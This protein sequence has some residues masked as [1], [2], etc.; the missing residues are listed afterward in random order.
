MLLVIASIVEASKKRKPKKRNTVPSTTLFDTSPKLAEE[1]PVRLNSEPKSELG[2]GKASDASTGGAS[3][4]V[5]GDKEVIAPYVVPEG[6]D[7][8]S[9][10]AVE[11]MFKVAV[12]TRDFVWLNRNLG[13][14]SGRKHLLDYVIANGADFTAQ[15]IGNV[16][17]SKWCVLAALFDY[18]SK[19]LIDWVLKG[20]FYHDRDLY[21]LTLYRPELADPP[22]KFFN[23]LDRIK[24]PE[25]R[26]FAVRQCIDEV[27]ITGKHD[28]VTLL[29]DALG[30]RTFHGKS[31]QDVAIRAAFFEGTTR[32]IPNIAR[33]YCEHP[34]INPEWYAYNI[35][36]A[37]ILGGSHQAFLLLLK[38]A[39]QDDLDEAN[40]EYASYDQFRQAI[41]KAP[42][43][44]PPAGSRYLRLIERTVLEVFASIM[45]GS[46]EHGPGGIVSAYILGEQEK[47]KESESGKVQGTGTE[48]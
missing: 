20:I 48:H 10:D 41:G 21:N 25:N 47:T 2:K 23:L 6:C 31:L 12:S 33:A 27:L 42:K 1:I 35:W 30:K 9:V 46:D 8:V 14:W 34:A 32:G 29:V 15:I 26:V 36:K 22:E 28:S 37:W 43:P 4:H 5:G 45:N 17:H 11:D 39:G 38:Q 44:I 13:S 24:E 7:V 40:R 3:S 19:V 16:I 18:G